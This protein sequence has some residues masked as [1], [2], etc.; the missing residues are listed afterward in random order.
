MT[1]STRKYS[2]G[3]LSQ[4]DFSDLGLNSQDDLRP[5]LLNN[6]FRL[7]SFTTYKQ[8]V[9]SLN[10]MGYT[11][12]A[13]ATKV[14]VKL[15]YPVIKGFLV[16]LVYFKRFYKTHTFSFA[17]TS[18]LGELLTFLGKVHKLAPVFDL[19]RAKENAK[20]LKVKLQEMCFFPHFT[21]QVAI[22]VFVT[23]IN[24][25]F[26]KKKLIRENVRL[27]CDCSAYSFHRTRKK[28]GLG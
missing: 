28:L 22:I 14:P 6:L 23:D 7:V 10:P 20:I 21:T 2:L 25:K 15:I 1:Q 24:D 8:K 4:F 17:E 19:S 13:S 18:Q 3:V 5:F 16:D 26:H 11:K 9:S 27:L 12:L